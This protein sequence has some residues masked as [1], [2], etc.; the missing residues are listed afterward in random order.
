MIIQE[1]VGVLI[2]LAAIAGYINYKYVK[3]PKSIGITLVTL[4]LSLFIVVG[5]KLNTNIEAFSRSLL[6]GIGFNDTFLHGMLSFLLFA[7]SLHINVIELSKYKIL[8]VLLATSSVF[9]STFFIGYSLFILTHFLCI[10]LPF[11][12]CF[13]F[14]ALISPT[15]PIAVLGVLKTVRAPKSLELKIAGEALFNDGMGIVLFFVALAL[16]SGT[17]KS[18]SPE[19]IFFYFLKQGIGGLF[20]GA[21]I[22]YLSSKL[23]STIDD[24]E[25]S[26]ILTLSIV[27]GGYILAHSIMDV[28]GPICMVTCGLVIG[29]SMKHFDVGD[30]T[31]NRVGA[32]WELLDEILNAVLFVLIGLEFIGIK[33]DLHTVLSA[34]GVIFI[35]IFSRW[36][37]IF[38][39]VVSFSRFKK[40]NAD[41]LIIL[42]WGGL[43]GGIS[44]ALALSTEGKYHNFIVAI[45]YAVVIFSMMFQGIT[46]SMLLR[47]FMKKVK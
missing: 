41:T 5:S 32:F 9:F 28:S 20:V 27:S 47:Y 30:E 13:V 21:I 44:I 24:Y 19:D 33:F 12:Y 31:I 4:I 39:P 15:D 1:V 8:V 37:S 14:G 18:L 3:L 38:I 29:N 11:Y 23:L 22:G 42:T 36:I 35:T 16:A 10:N 26:I 46:I 34:I 7:G 17:Q 6:A 43:R 25:V 2:S 40:F 45:T